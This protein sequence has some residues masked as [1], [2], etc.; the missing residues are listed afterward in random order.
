MMR[1]NYLIEVYFLVFYKQR[2][3]FVYVLEYFDYK[4]RYSRFVGE[5]WEIIE[6]IKVSRE[7]KKC[8]QFNW[9]GE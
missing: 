9:E 5:C 2:S 1:I 7:E 8:L 4:E 3:K 6:K